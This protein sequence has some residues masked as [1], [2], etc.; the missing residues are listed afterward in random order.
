MNHDFFVGR[1]FHN[2]MSISCQM[3]DNFIAKESSDFFDRQALSLW[4][5]KVDEY[6]GDD[7]KTAINN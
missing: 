2:S 3:H 1:I 5:P 4:D 7:A 6:G